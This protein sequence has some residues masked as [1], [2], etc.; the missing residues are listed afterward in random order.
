MIKNLME[1]WNLCEEDLEIYLQSAYTKTFPKNYKIFSSAQEC[2]GLVLILNG[3]LRS[4]I[5]SPNNK[6]V[7]L[8]ILKSGEFCILSASCLFKNLSFEIHLEFME[9]SSVW[10]LPSKT[11]QALSLKYPIAKQFQMDLISERLSRVVSSLNSLAFDSLESR[12]LEF[13]RDSLERNPKN[14]QTLYI[15]HE[16]IANALGSARE[17][18]SRALKNLEKQGKLKLKRGMIELIS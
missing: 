17:S 16:E 9:T 4:F 13:L 2:R 11:F 14:F 15:T 5:V 6:E 12:I 8:F 18:I 1:S 7:N 3:A 10:I